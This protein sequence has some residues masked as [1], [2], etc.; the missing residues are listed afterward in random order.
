M[1]HTVDSIKQEIYTTIQENSSDK[2]KPEWKKWFIGLTI[3]PNQEK[4][5]R[6]K[7]QCWNY[8]KAKTAKEAQEIESYF[9]KKYPINK[10]KERGEYDYFIFIYKT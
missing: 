1:E 6:G 9:V 10:N 5:K 4:N 2:S 8:W 7:P 3:Y